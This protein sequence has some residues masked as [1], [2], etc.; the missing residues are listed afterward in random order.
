MAGRETAQCRSPLQPTCEQND[1]VQKPEREKRVSHG[2][3]QIKPDNHVF[4]QSTA[5]CP[6]GGAQQH[7]C[8]V[9]SELERTVRHSTARAETSTGVI[10]G[11]ACRS[12]CANSTP[13]TRTRFSGGT[14]GHLTR[15]QARRIM[16]GVFAD[17]TSNRRIESEAL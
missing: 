14:P 17:P 7:E 3:Q 4:S 2:E 15:A 9:G 12:W 1:R 5:R 8:A 10:A 13:P 16:T 6:R 11:R